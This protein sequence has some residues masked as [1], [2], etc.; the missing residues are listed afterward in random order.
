MTENCNAEIITNSDGY[1]YIKVDGHLISHH[2]L[3]ACR[4]DDPEYVAQRD[5]HH[6]IPIEW[7][8]VPQNIEPVCRGEHAQIHTDSDSFDERDI[9]D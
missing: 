4:D 1:E 6:C 8:N 9:L 2:R 5:C 7:L 3:L